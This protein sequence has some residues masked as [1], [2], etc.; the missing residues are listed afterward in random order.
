[1]KV[2]I[3]AGEASG[4]IH[5]A[6]L[7]SALRA[8]KPDVSFAGIGGSAMQA[9]GLQ[10][11]VPLESMSVVGF[12]EVAKQYGFFKRTL[13]LAAQTMREMKADLFLAVDYPG[14]NTRLAAEARRAH[15]PVAWYIAPQFW[16]WGAQRAKNFARVV[17]ALMVVFPFE[18]E[19]F[20]GFGIEAEFVGHPLLD[21]PAF[22]STPPL[23]ADR[24][25]AIAFLPGSRQQEIHR[26]LP[27]FRDVARRLQDRFP[28]YSRVLARNPKIPLELYEELVDDADL[29]VYE[30]DSRQVMRNARV[31]L[32]KTGTSTLEASLC[33]LPHCMMYK[34]STLSYHIARRLVRLPYISLTNILAQKM[35]VREFVQS[36][37]QAAS[38]STELE[39]LLSQQDAAQE[40]QMQCLE[41]RHL[42]GSQ[43]AAQRAA[44]FILQRFAS[45][46]RSA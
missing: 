5:A 17:D 13:R 27:L 37:A 8:A 9:E 12:V 29:F 39:R 30:T 33:G 45:S 41:L 24:A 26:H 15:I 35:L 7:M 6:R 32:I 28:E 3:V 10:S 23:L 38:I 43:G 25:P 34:T 4:D 21:D 31:G 22:A 18:V 16:A 40:L 11:I 42:L 14:F 36:D 1:M 2:F 20:G 19:F 46:T 44:Q